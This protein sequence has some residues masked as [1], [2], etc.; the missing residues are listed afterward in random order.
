MLARMT[1]N[2]LIGLAAAF[3]L[4]TGAM[5]QDAPALWRVADEDTTIYF[6][7]RLVQRPGEDGAG[8]EQHPS[9]RNRHEP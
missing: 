8:R 4:T 1:R 9:H 3:S 5:A 7:R 2:T 6:R